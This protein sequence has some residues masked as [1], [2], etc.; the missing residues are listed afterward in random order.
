VTRKKN[1]YYLPDGAF[2]GNKKNYEAGWNKFFRLLVIRDIIPKSS[3]LVSFDP[4]L[5]T[6]SPCMYLPEG[7]VR[8]MYEKFRYNSWY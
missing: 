1:S 7:V 6:A 2:C 3:K 8:L 4:H 5:E